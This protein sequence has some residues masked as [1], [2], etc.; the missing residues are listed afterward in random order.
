M[1]CKASQHGYNVCFLVREFQVQAVLLCM[2]SCYEL[3]LAHY[4]SRT[5]LLQTE[6][7]CVQALWQCLRMPGKHLLLGSLN[8][9]VSACPRD[10]RHDKPECCMNGASRHSTVTGRRCQGL[11]EPAS[12]ERPGSN[13]G[14]WDTRRNPWL[15]RL[16]QGIHW[17]LLDMLI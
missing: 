16:S 13:T 1:S 7:F 15:L 12:W 2:D 3:S 14:P 5:R 9:I 17:I 10:V 4:P 6:Y 11:Y 8:S